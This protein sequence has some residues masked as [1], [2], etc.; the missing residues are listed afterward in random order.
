MR[1]I[2]RGLFLSLFVEM[3]LI[4]VQ[5]GVCRKADQRDPEQLYSHNGEQIEHDAVAEQ[6]D[7]HDQQSTEERRDD[8][9]TESKMSVLDIS[10]KVGFNTVRTFNRAFIKN[11]ET[12]PRDYRKK[13]GTQGV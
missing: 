7:Q 8:L 3:K 11:M 9:H 6:G 1:K 4:G 12:S 13:A 10:E 2:V 5:L